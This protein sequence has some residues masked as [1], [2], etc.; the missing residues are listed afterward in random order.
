MT[1]SGSDPHTDLNKMVAE[2]CSCTC[3]GRVDPKVATLPKHAAVR[4]GLER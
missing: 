1:D 4:Q 2:E 3:C